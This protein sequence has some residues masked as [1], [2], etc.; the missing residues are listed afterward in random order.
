[1]IDRT[2]A[3][4]KVVLYY[5]D[6]G[7]TSA[8]AKTRAASMEML[9]Q[10]FKKRGDM[11]TTSSDGG[12]LW[13][14]IGAFIKSPDSATRSAALDCMAYL[15][16]VHG[17]VIYQVLG[18]LPPRDRDLLDKRIATLGLGSSTR[19]SGIPVHVK[20]S[21]QRAANGRSSP[22]PPRSAP[23]STQSSPRSETSAARPASR[24]QEPLVVENANGRRETAETPSPPAALP[25]PRSRPSAESMSSTIGN[26]LT[27]DSDKSVEALKKVQR[28]L[29]VSPE[30]VQGSVQELI[31]AVHSQL[32]RIFL[33]PDALEDP[34][35]FRLT[36]HLVQTMSNFCDH[37][38]LVEQVD[39][40]NM[41][42]LLEQLTVG[43]LRTDMASADSPIKEMSRYMNMTILRLFATGRRGTIFR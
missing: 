11:V 20:Q 27:A 15:Y 2:V 26:I 40:D 34:K 16:K 32:Q 36:K 24:M 22:A 35:V 37:Q 25:R 17:D 19:P 23:P 21:P 12:K 28:V 8:S 14:R 13:K 5:Q 7:I 3:G 42:I 18:D 33:A 43:L 39:P 31:E 29:E 38:T 9:A 1:M 10:L 4:S 41:M 30:D 6:H